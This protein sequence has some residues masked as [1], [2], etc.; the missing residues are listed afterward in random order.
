MP[1]RE[2]LATSA[3]VKVFPLASHEKHPDQAIKDPGGSY[4]RFDTWT[5][6]ILQDL[7]DSVRSCSTRASSF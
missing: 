2:A 1:I 6:S 4:L 7:Y 5:D 3:S